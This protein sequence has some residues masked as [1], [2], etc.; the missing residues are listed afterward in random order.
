M[1]PYVAVMGAI[2]F[3]ARWVRRDNVSTVCHLGGM[4][5]GDLSLRRVR[6]IQR[7]QHR[8]RLAVPAQSPALRGFYI[9]SKRRNRPPP[10]QLGH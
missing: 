3:F 6:F 4:L 2:E 8:H 9:N 10:R 5:V 7:P 1:R